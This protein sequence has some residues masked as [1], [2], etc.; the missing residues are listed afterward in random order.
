MRKKDASPFDIGTWVVYPAH[1]VGHLDDIEV[2]DIDGEK[3]EFFVISFKKNKLVLKIPVQKAVNAG[4]RSI[5]SKEEQALV[6]DTLVQKRKKRRMMWSK[7]AQE[8]EFKINSGDPV[9]I[10]EVLRDLYKE[11]GDTAQ[12]F[13]ERQIFQNAMDRLARE[14]AVLD[15]IEEE[16]AVKK[17]ESILKAA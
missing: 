14:I 3:I 9:A 6:F 17:L 7:R 11:G 16:E 8:Y 1:G 12:S 10:A 4:L 5:L 13:S 15:E 2:L